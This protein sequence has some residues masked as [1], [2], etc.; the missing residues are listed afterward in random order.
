MLATPS[1]IDE[2]K[3]VDELKGKLP[4]E[5]NGLRFCYLINLFPF[6]IPCRCQLSQPRRELSDLVL[7]SLS[8]SR[9]LLIDL[10]HVLLDL[11]E[12]RLRLCHLLLQPHDVV[13]ART[14]MGHTLTVDQFKNNYFAEL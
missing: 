12:L 7:R 5:E 13:P 2:T 1:P 3:S 9:A 8:I 10:V 11:A 6:L 4:E 14:S